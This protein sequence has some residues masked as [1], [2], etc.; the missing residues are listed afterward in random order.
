[1]NNF[2]GNNAH[3]TVNSSIGPTVGPGFNMRPQTNNAPHN[4]N[5]RRQHSQPKRPTNRS[6][7]PQA[8]SMNAEVHIP[9][10]D[11]NKV[12]LTRRQLLFGAIGVAAIAGVG[13]GAAAISKSQKEEKSFDV[14][15]VPVSNVSTT[16][17]MDGESLTADDCME[18]SASFEMPY[19]TLIWAN[20]SHYAACLI[21]TDT[22]SPLSIAAII[23]LD[24]G[25]YETILEQAVTKDPGY[26]IFD[27]RATDNAVIW[28]EAHCLAN[29]WKTYQATYSPGNGIGTPILLAEG[30]ENFEAPSLA[31]TSKHVYWQILPSL[32]SSMKSE[33][34]LIYAA[35]IGSSEATEVVRSHGRMCTPLYATNDGVACSPRVSTSGVYHQLSFIDDATLSITD[36]VIMPGGMKPLE[37]GY[38]N[39]RFSFAFDTIYN[40]GNGIAN[41]GTYVPTSTD[42]PSDSKWVCFDRNPTAAPA[43]CKNWFVVKST[44]GVSCVD[45]NTNVMFSLGCPDGTDTYGDYLATTGSFDVIVT[46]CNIDKTQHNTTYVEGTRNAKD[47]EIN[48]GRY[49]AEVNDLHHTLVRVWKPYE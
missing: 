1:M 45:V 4:S 16:A 31:I 44:R 20:S 27:I 46:Y 3:Q 36:S 17:N 40:Y 32:T 18:L 33:D 9:L 30:D 24:S 22:S 5:A 2:I 28:T 25:T 6:D 48:E 8:T 14:L 49:V 37:A 42:N 34:S 15:T 26:E 39:S 11:N 23:S 19:G 43:W 29:V 47:G 41:L 10:L 21:P 7:S 38:G 13:A 35:P 12:I